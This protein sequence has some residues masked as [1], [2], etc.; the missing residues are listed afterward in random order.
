[1]KLFGMKAGASH[2]EFIILKETG[3]IYFVETSSRV[4]GAHL[5]EMV[6]AA[7]NVNL[8][9]ERT[10]IEDAMVKNLRY[11]LP[12]SNQKKRRNSTYLSQREHPDLSIFDDE[13]VYFKVI[14]GY[15]A[16]LI[17][18]S[19]EKNRVMEL[20]NSYAIRFAQDLSTVA[21]APELKKFH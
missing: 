7:T 10:K 4:G 2:T 6:E 16:G 9:A 5:A 3:E 14:L 13:E 20:L 12:K 17:V 19:R 15:H 11:Q 18:K 8:W 1:M 21:D